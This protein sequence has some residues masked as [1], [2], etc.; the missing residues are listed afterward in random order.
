MNMLI[1]DKINSMQDG[2]CRQRD[3]NPRKEMMTIKKK[4]YC[5][6]NEKHF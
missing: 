2:Q 5:N 1:M 3:G 6:R 4:K